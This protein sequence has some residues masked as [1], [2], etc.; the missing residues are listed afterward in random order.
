M[1]QPSVF[2]WDFLFIMYDFG[3]NDFEFHFSHL[4]SNFE[5]QITI[6]LETEAEAAVRIEMLFFSKW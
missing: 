5:F 1:T 4:S 3:L 6:Q 2:V